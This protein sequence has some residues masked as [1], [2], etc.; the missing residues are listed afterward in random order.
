[1]GKPF[2]QELKKLET[3]YKWALSLPIG[4]IDSIKNY[5]SKKPLFVVGSGGS[6]S[7]CVN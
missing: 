3:T 7:A 4:N 6:L 1:M 5:L 2:N